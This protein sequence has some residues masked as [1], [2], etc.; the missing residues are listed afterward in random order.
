[1]IAPSA[2]AVI[3]AANNTK[4]NFGI[5]RL[6]IK[7]DQSLEDAAAIPAGFALIACEGHMVGL[8]CEDRLLVDTGVRGDEARLC[9]LGR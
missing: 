2:F 7:Y 6:M 8:R 5:S 9:Q 4:M 3:L 1:M